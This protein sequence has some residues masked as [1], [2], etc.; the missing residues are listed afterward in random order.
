MKTKL[1]SFKHSQEHKQTPNGSLLYCGDPLAQKFAGK[2]QMEFRNLY[3]YFKNMHI[4][5]T[6]I[7]LLLLLASYIH[8][9]DIPSNLATAT[10]KI[11]EANEGSQLAHLYTGIIWVHDPSPSADTSDPTLDFAQ[12]LPGGIFSST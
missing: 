2:I 1:E 5:S 11:F 8:T 4:R 12:T 7:L 6:G 9:Q 3:T 10:K